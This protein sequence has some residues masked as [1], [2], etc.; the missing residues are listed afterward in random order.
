MISSLSRCARRASRRS[1][2]VVTITSSR[3]RQ[4]SATPTR[5]PFPP[6]NAP[7]TAPPH[8]AAARSLLCIPC[9][10]FSRSG[11]TTRSAAA[12]PR[13]SR[14]A[15][16]SGSA[17]GIDPW[18]GVCGVRTASH[19]RG[20]A[21]TGLPAESTC[22]PAWGALSSLLLNVTCGLML[23]HS[24]PLLEDG[25]AEKV[26]MDSDPPANDDGPPLCAERIA[27]AD[28]PCAEGG[29]DAFCRDRHGKLCGFHD[30]CH[31]PDYPC[32]DL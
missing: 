2:S 25:M 32:I 11:P 4:S 15:G 27:K 31:A 14:P 8:G 17:D 30:L 20:A 16:A 26:L 29:F 6:R 19:S 18:L 12:G 23:L 9:S 3:R 21:P 7:G 13:S 24:S 10:H 22:A 1:G 5:R 28:D